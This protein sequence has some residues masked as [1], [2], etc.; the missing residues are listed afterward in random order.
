MEKRI[1][2]LEF[3][4]K[5]FYPVWP[6]RKQQTINLIECVGASFLPE[7]ADSQKVR[8]KLQTL[9]ENKQ[10]KLDKESTIEMS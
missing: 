10:E 4:F 9:M 3:I 5:A 1:E 2:I 6:S 8:D 7:L